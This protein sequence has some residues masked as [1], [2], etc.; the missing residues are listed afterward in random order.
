M[1]RTIKFY[2]GVLSFEKVTDQTVRDPNYLRLE[3]VPVKSARVVR[4]RLGDEYIELTQFPGTEIR[5]VP[6][7]SHSNDRWFQ[8]IAIVV[9]DMRRAYKQL[10]D[11]DVEQISLA[12]QLE[13][14]SST[15]GI[16]TGT[17]LRSFI[18]PAISRNPMCF[19]GVPGWASARVFLCATPTAT[20]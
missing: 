18:I 3:G 7:D 11:A 12:L 5:R 8:H 16:P 13:S 15:S 17:R 14:K 10:Y 19:S 9:S 1:D 6:A 20:Q 2:S 4:M